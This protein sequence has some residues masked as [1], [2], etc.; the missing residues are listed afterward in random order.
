MLTTLLLAS[1][2]DLPKYGSVSIIRIIIG[3]CRI[4]YFIYYLAEVCQFLEQKAV[5]IMNNLVVISFFRQE[6]QNSD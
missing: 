1:F 5:P 3:F 2:S 6:R 4:S